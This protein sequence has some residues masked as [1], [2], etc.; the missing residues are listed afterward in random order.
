MDRYFFLADG[1]NAEM[2][3]ADTQGKTPVAHEL[4]SLLRDETEVP[5]DLFLKKNRISDNGL[6]VSDDITGLKYLWLDFQ[7]N[8]LAWNLMSSRMKEI[9]DKNLTGEEGI[10]WMKVNIKSP[11]E[12]RTYFIPRFKSIL[13]VL[14]EERTIYVKGTSHIVKPVFSLAKVKK[15]NVFFVNGAAWEIPSGLY[16]SEMMKRVIQKEKLT[17][18]TFELVSSSRVV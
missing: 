18:V 13:D 7:P 11:T 9:V 15:F 8:N 14:D 4:I 16:I 1:A 17:G 10:V 6:E 3:F 2:A 5:F 12:V